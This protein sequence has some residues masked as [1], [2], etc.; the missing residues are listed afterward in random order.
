MLFCIVSV[1]YM[2]IVVF[3]WRGEWDGKRGF[4]PRTYVSEMSSDQAVVGTAAGV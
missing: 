1:S 4:F 3:R 2:K